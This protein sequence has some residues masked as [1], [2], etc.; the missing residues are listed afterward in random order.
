MPNAES[1][2]TT[3]AAIAAG[4]KNPSAARALIEFLASP[5]GKEVMAKSGLDPTK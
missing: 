5:R 3:L 4:S 2:L 1:L